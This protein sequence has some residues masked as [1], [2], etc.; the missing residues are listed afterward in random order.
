MS[1]NFGTPAPLGGGTMFSTPA[2]NNNN[3]NTP[4]GGGA[5][6]IVRFDTTTSASGSS[7][8]T[9]FGTPAAATSAGSGQT[10][11][12]LLAAP[13]TT[14][15]GGGL[16]LGGALGGQPSLLS[17]LGAT[18]KAAPVLTFNS[19][20]T[21]GLGGGLTSTVPQQSTIG[22]STGFSFSGNLGAPAASSA[23]TGL[24]GFSTAA[25][26]NSGA[27]ASNTGLGTTATC[28]V[29][30]SD[31]SYTECCIFFINM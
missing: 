28:Q 14:G 5:P 3:N 15:T 9:G 17:Q 10:L 16:G 22:S 31:L 27:I 24:F 23:A 13:Q 4:Q 26:A 7:P 2:A 29:I 21:G 30:S 1:F 19:G 25:A 6:K 20:L 8:F 12:G 18:T 11:A